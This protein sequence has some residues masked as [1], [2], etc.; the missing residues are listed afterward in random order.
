V[1][2]SKHATGQSRIG[3]RNDYRRYYSSGVGASAS[4]RMVGDLGSHSSHHRPSSLGARN[5]WPCCRR[6]ESL[7]LK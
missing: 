3:E 6:Q 5:V 1:D 7:V 2:F 4:H